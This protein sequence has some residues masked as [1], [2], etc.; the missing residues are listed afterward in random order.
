MSVISMGSAAS[1]PT[2]STLSL[3]DTMVKEI[4]LKKLEATISEIEHEL[5]SLGFAKVIG[6]VTAKSDDRKVKHD[7]RIR[8]AQKVSIKVEVS[9]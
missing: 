8:Y 9:W 2:D 3:C 6:E 7:E 5:K 4:E 1:S